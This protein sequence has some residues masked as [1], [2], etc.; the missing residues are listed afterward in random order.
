LPLQKLPLLLRLPLLLKL[1]PLLELL[2][3]QV[4]PLPLAPY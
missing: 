4:L 3:V 2:L 1:P